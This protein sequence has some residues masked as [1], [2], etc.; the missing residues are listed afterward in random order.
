MDVDPPSVTNTSILGESANADDIVS[1]GSPE[2]WG[3]NNQISRY[4]L[5]VHFPTVFY[6]SLTIL[7]QSL[8]TC[9]NVMAAT[10]N[11]VALSSIVCM[12]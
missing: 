3:L 4:D 2:D 9:A 11:F 8:T 12:A 10:R 5:Y 6:H 7:A 1:L